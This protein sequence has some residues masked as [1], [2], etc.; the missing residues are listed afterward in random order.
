MMKFIKQFRDLGAENC[1]ANGMC[2]WFAFIL[3]A[4]FPGGEIVYD[5]IANHF[6]Y[7]FSDKIYDITGEIDDGYTWKQW[8][9]FS[10]TDKLLYN[11]IIRDCINKEDGP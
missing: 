6:A 1:F 8:S 5:E 2:Y 7:K 11:R 10:E 9:T 4:R 3:E